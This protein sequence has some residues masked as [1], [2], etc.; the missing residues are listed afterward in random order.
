MPVQMSMMATRNSH[1]D[2]LPGETCHKPSVVPPIKW[3]NGGAG[4]RGASVVGPA[5]ERR[6]L[7]RLVLEL[8]QRQRIDLAGACNGIKNNTR[9]TDATAFT[10]HT[11]ILHHRNTVHLKLCQQ[12][13]ILCYRF[14]STSIVDLP[15]LSQRSLSFSSLFVNGES[16]GYLM[17]PPW[18]SECS[19]NF[20]S[21][22]GHKCVFAHWH[23]C[24][25]P[26][27]RNHWP[28]PAAP[29]AVGVLPMAN[30]SSGT[31]LLAAAMLMKSSA[32]RR[33]VHHP[34]P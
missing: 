27:P 5:N 7:W 15:V 3:R 19:G 6:A 30:Q 34:L 13:E 2:G 17:T 32:L 29:V 11:P 22:V 24:P 14:P 21:S 1:A 12:L 28:I 9:A 31:S 33:A 25:L 26:P 8:Q 20:Q 16:R 18:G 4:E 23:W 10:P